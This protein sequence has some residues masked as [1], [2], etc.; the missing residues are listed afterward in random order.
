MLAAVLCLTGLY[1]GKRE[2]L[3]SNAEAANEYTTAPLALP[4]HLTMPPLPPESKVLFIGDSWAQGVGAVDQVDGNWAAL[5]ADYFGWDRTIDGMGGT[6]FTARGAS[7]TDDNRCSN[8]LDRWIDQGMEQDLVV[9][10]GGLNDDDVEP[11]NLQAAV[12]DAVTK[13]RGAWPESSI[14]VIGPAAPQPLAD[15]VKRIAEP[16]RLGAIDAGA[17][18][19][20]PALLGW[21]TEE[22]SEAF[23][24]P[25]DG[26]HVNDESHQYTSERL[27]DAIQKLQ[28]DQQG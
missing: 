17:F 5:T 2:T 27:I 10:E 6:G 14:L 23:L 13:A 1:L 11:S 22:N 12:R 15:M 21:F 4:S 19:I 18:S 3:Q 24:I 26:A 8:R 28:G 20:Q 9:L 7:G 16:I 25:A